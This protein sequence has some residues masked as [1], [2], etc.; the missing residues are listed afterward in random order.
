MLVCE[1]FLRKCKEIAAGFL[2]EGKG[3]CLKI[4]KL[5]FLGDL[6]YDFDSVADDIIEMGRWIKDNGYSVILNLEGGIDCYLEHRIK[7][8]GPNL[9][10][11]LSTIEILKVLNVVGVTLANN[12]MLDF[13]G[14][15]LLHTIKLLDENGIQ[16]TGAGENLNNAL[17][18]M[19]FKTGDHRN[20]YV[21]SAGWDVEE[22]VYA[23]GKTAGCAPRK[24]N[25][26][27]KTIG[28][29][30]SSDNVVIACLHWGFEYNRL[31]MPVDINLAHMLISRGVYTVIGSHPHVVQPKEEYMNRMIYYSLGNFY[32]SG[33]RKRFERKF[34]NE[35]IENQSDYGVGVGMDLL[36]NQYEEITIVYN[37]EKD[38]SYI[39]P[40]DALVLEQLRHEQ[41]EN[42]SAY[43]NEVKIRKR[44]MNPILTGKRVIDPA[45]ITLLKAR[46]FAG[47]VK[48]KILNEE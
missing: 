11:S 2:C 5:L 39:I 29:Y 27:L 28:S 14:Q 3:Y 33:R 44:N 7:K 22:T 9:S 4:G 24:N 10:S 12:H 35:A 25:L 21:F 17:K 15:S 37:R 16:H 40:Q 8:R 13:G 42:K 26:L 41:M 18:P 47:R 19:C 46:H 34:P 48:R 31:P 43:I 30:L 1:R 20:L 32:F 6:Y 45:K 36:K 23:R 38:R